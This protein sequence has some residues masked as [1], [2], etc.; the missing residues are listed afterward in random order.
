MLLNSG[1]QFCRTSETDMDTFIQQGHR[2][3]GNLDAK[4]KC[5]LAGRGRVG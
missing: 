2:I 3:L 5:F 4:E 1:V